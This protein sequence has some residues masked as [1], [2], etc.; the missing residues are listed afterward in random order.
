M[1]VPGED[2]RRRNTQVTFA[3]TQQCHWRC[4][5]RLSSSQED[6]ITLN[7]SV[8]SFLQHRFNR[9]L[10]HFPLPRNNPLHVTMSLSY[11]IDY[12]TLRKNGVRSGTHRPGTLPSHPNAPTNATI[13]LQGAPARSVVAVEFPRGCVAPLPGLGA[14]AWWRS[15]SILTDDQWIA[16][17]PV[18]CAAAEVTNQGIRGLGRTRPLSPLSPELASTAGAQR[19][20]PGGV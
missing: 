12:D 20:A 9:S 16:R 7:P 1:D 5:T 14:P 6:D 19:R 13:Q 18:C 2:V 11:N 15:A 3:V 10:A 8:L 4:L 17:L